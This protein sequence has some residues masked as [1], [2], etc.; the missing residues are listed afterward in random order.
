MADT[1]MNTTEELESSGYEHLVD[2]GQ[3]L[4]DPYDFVPRVVTQTPGAMEDIQQKLRIG[5]MALRKHYNESLK[6]NPEKWKALRA[7]ASMQ[8]TQR[9][10]AEMMLSIPDVDRTQFHEMGDGSVMIRRSI[11]GTTCKIKSPI[12]ICL[13]ELT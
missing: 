4:E 11:S 12:E 9:T 1:N 5:G 7:P 10:L 2:S 3:P 6:K 13:E 8:S